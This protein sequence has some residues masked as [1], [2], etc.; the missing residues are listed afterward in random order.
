VA[1]SFDDSLDEE[2]WGLEGVVRRRVSLLLLFE[3]LLDALDDLVRLW[4]FFDKLLVDVEGLELL[5]D[6]D[7]VPH[8]GRRSELV[9][10]DETSAYSASGYS[11]W[12]SSSK[13]VP[14]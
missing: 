13:L 4:L 5:R 14:V 2:P 7:E 9:V 10:V 1:L 3:D 8:A 12:A 6:A 11:S